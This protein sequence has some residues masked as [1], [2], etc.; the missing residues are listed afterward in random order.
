M[1]PMGRKPSRFPGKT[2]YHPKYGEVNWWEAELGNDENKKAERQKAR[3]E[4]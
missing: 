2:D 4:I 3:K 1:Q